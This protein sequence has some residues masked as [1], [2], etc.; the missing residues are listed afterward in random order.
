LLDGAFGNFNDLPNKSLT[1]ALRRQLTRPAP[2]WPVAAHQTRIARL[3]APAKHLSA[4]RGQDP[5][6]FNGDKSLAGSAVD[7]VEASFFQGFDPVN[8]LRPPQAAR[9]TRAI[10]RVKTSEVHASMRSTASGVA[11]RA[12]A[13]EVAKVWG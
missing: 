3:S 5:H 1:S 8:G 4:S 2:L 7:L 9:G 10:D 13:V 6:F 11:A 12:G